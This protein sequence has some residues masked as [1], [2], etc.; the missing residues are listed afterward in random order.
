PNSLAQRA[1]KTPLTFVPRT[2]QTNY[3]KFARA[4]AAFTC[5]SYVGMQGGEQPVNLGDS[6]TDF[7]VIH[8]LGHAIGF[9]HEQSRN[10]RDQYVQVHFENVALACVYNYDTYGA[11][12][13]EA[14][15]YDYASAMHYYP[16]AYSRNSL[17]VMVTIP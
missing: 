4:A 6:C 2:N 12:G 13:R 16:Y 11:R 3:L 15:P 7:A 17:P 1:A 8:E 9:W 5:N 14:S 10:D